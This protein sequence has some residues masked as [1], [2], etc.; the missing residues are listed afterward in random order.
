MITAD[1]L[2]VEAVAE[3]EMMVMDCTAF[4]WLEDSDKTI[5]VMRPTAAAADDDD[6]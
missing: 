2:G 6:R 1:D 4:D 5:S 3:C